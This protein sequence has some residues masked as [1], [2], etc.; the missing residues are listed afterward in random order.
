MNKKIALL[1]LLFISLLTSP[2]LFGDDAIRIEQL[3]ARVA[4]PIANLIV[5][6]RHILRIS[7]YQH[8]ANLVIVGD[9]KTEP[10]SSSVTNMEVE[11]YVN[12]DTSTITKLPLKDIAS[13]FE[14]KEF[15][16]PLG[17]GTFSYRFVIAVDNNN[18]EQMYYPYNAGWIHV[19]VTASTST[20]IT[21]AG[22]N[23]IL[24]NGDQRYGHSEI[25]IKQG[26]F[27]SDSLVTMQESDITYFSGDKDGLLKLYEIYS[28]N[29]LSLT[30]TITLYYGSSNEGQ[31]VVKYFNGNKWEKVNFTPTQ[32]TAKKTITFES[33]NRGFFGIF[34]EGSDESSG[35]RPKYKVFRPGNEL[36]F[37]N[38]G[39]G[40]TVTI[41]DINGREIARLTSKP[42]K[43]NGR[44]SS[45]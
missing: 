21:T 7:P 14:S 18:S 15:T 9:Y 20:T 2:F 6:H 38:L 27:S 33:N 37:R 25:V 34:V 8:E 31:Y 39:T 35:H 30:A 23:L 40:D 3:S 19:P 22:G 4:I 28:D 45:G 43:W 16:V 44:K 11:Y 10:D 32:D 42:F 5:N 29:P 12:N 1:L 24:D 41:F 13:P 36:E 26:T 17:I